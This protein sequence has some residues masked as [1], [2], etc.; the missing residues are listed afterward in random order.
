MSTDKITRSNGDPPKTQRASRSRKSSSPES[1]NTTPTATAKA[2]VKGEAPA[3][4]EKKVAEPEPLQIQTD[5]PVTA[6]VSEQ[7]TT[8]TVVTADPVDNPV[9][10]PEGDVMASPSKEAVS[11]LPPAHEGELVPHPSSAGLVPTVASTMTIA[12]GERPIMT[13]NLVVTQMMGNRPIFASDLQVYETIN[14][15][16]LRPVLASPFEVVGSLDAAGHRPIGANEFEIVGTINIS[17]IRPIGVSTLHVTEMLT[18]S[19]PIASNDID[20][21]PALMGYID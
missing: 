2:E 7:P 3:V 8:D 4:P 9:D 5:V 19:R 16:G 21:A 15:S 20:D 11:A 18:A 6:P 14:A 12:G 17:G 13:S 1:A 10:N